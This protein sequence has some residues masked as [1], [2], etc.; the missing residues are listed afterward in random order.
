MNPVVSSYAKRLLIVT[1][2]FGLLSLALYFILPKIWFSPSLPFLFIFYYACSLLSFILLSR[3]LE[4]RSNR[5]I[6]V[7]ML[8]TAIKLFLFITVMI[9]YSF[10]NRKDAVA[11]LL[12]FFILYLV[13]TVF[14]VV[15]IISLTKSSS[16]VEKRNDG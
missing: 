11:F 8:T 12:N 2:S 15:Q 13:Y 16:A 10:L 3:S 1:L 4:A 14:E 7:F 5:F 9:I 6:S